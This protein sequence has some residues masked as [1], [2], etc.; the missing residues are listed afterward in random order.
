MCSFYHE[1]LRT[2]VKT[3]AIKFVISNHT[4]L[5]SGAHTLRSYLKLICEYELHSLPNKKVS[6]A[7]D[8]G[9]NYIKVRPPLV[10]HLLSNRLLNLVTT[11]NKLLMGNSWSLRV[12]RKK[13]LNQHR[14][15]NKDYSLHGSNTLVC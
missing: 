3:I 4:V 13:V 7:K 5:I 11:L 8:H 6:G 1:P 10:R 2:W 15:L 12:Y 14:P 9:K